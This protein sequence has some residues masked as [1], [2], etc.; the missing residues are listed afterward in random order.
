MAGNLTNIPFEHVSIGG[1]VGDTEE[2]NG[3]AGSAYTEN[4]N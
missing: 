1:G 4:T 2:L 3:A